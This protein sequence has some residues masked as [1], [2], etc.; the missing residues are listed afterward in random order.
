MK[1]DKLKKRYG[2]TGGTYQD[3]IS[4]ILQENAKVIH[5][6]VVSVNDDHY[7]KVATRFNKKSAKRFV[8]PDIFDEIPDSGLQLRKSAEKGQL[9]SDTLKDDLRNNLREVLD[10]KT[11]VT[12]QS[13]LITQTGKKAGTINNHL[14]D[15][16][17]KK[18]TETFANYIKDDPN[19][20]MPS[21]IK[22]IATTEVRSAVHDIQHSYVT[23]LTKRNPS[24]RIFKKWIHNPN[25][26][27]TKPRDNH[28]KLG[29]FKAIPLEQNYIFQ[30][31]KGKTVSASRP[32]D[33]SLPP[34]EVIGCHCDIE[35]QGVYIMSDDKLQQVRK[36]LQNMVEKA[37]KTYEIG[38]R[39]KRADGEW[40]KVGQGK[41]KKVP[42]GRD[43]E[44]D[45]D[46]DAMVDDKKNMQSE[47]E[48]EDLDK[49]AD[50]A[51][52]L[53]ES[54][55]ITQEDL[56]NLS[57]E[58]I[59]EM[60]DQLMDEKAD[61]LGD[62]EPEDKLKSFLG[63][64]YV[65][66]GSP[67]LAMSDDE[68]E[69]LLE[70]NGGRDEIIENICAEENFVVEDFDDMS[71]QEIA[72]IGSALGFISDSSMSPEE[73]KSDNG[74][75]DRLRD[76]YG[77]SED[78]LNSMSDNELKELY[79][80][81]NGRPDLSESE[82]DNVYDSISEKYYDARGNGASH[83]KAMEQVYVSIGVMGVGQHDATNL[84]T[85]MEEEGQ[86]YKPIEDDEEEDSE[87][88]EDKD[89][90]TLK[91]KMIDEGV[92]T[93]EDF[94]KMSPEVRD[95]YN[96]KA[97]DFKH[98]DLETSPDN[99]EHGLTEDEAFESLKA[100]GFDDEEISGS[101]MSAQQMLHEYYTDSDIYNDTAKVQLKEEG[102][103]D[104]QIKDSGL[105]PK[106]LLAEYQKD[107]NPKSGKEDQPKNKID[108]MLGELS[109][110]GIDIN[111]LDDDR[112]IRQSYQ[113]MLKDKKKNGK[114]Y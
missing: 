73:S 4:K 108:D 10:L 53:I 79:V 31:E 105:S 99:W 23:E 39:A 51:M 96:M 24:L 9:I 95:S 72:E 61:E 100:E 56:D 77:Y 26:S 49:T 30:T 74:M 50:M 48:K 93:E 75:K 94:E 27:I 17:E 91:Q 32:H 80:D 37:R 46:V 52:N 1:L 6:H 21:N 45:K 64:D 25:L 7:K 68:A 42:A 63:D 67:Y 71:T 18:I 44:D 84:I 29:R 41:W 34:E 33:P 54:E 102:F 69:K 35:Y 101:G 65:A 8:V 111:G 58:E 86:E 113:D 60:H 43:E 97:E 70:E 14:I 36:S 19:A 20:K 107:M 3:L 5:K 66:E 83:D 81:E 28:A 15:L 85:K 109:D 103:T 98:E 90:R 38:D 11:G 62:S 87:D 92:Y 110:Y 47:M 12:G 82:L 76:D 114:R 57:P 16:Y 40:E 88:K 59:Q 104:K 55:I 2:I 106:E 22:T 78:E 13:K 112:A 89:D